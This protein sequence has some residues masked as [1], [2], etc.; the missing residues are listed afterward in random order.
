MK[1]VLKIH[2]FIFDTF[3]EISR[4]RALLLGRVG[5]GWVG[6][7]RFIVLKNSASPKIDIK[8]YFN[9]YKFF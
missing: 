3:R 7:A 1:G 6:P 9:S 8:I 2:G 4:Q 5:S